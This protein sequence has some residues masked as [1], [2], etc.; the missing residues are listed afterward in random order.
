MKKAITTA[1]LTS[2]LVLNL[3]A[4]G[5]KQTGMAAGASAE[6]KTST[7]A[8]S[9]ESLSR[10]KSQSLSK[11]AERGE[12]YPMIQ[13]ISKASTDLLKAMALTDHKF[14][15]ENNLSIVG[16]EISSFFSLYTTCL[17]ST[18]ESRAAFESMLDKDIS[19]N[20][21]DSDLFPFTEFVRWSKLSEPN[22]ERKRLGSNLDKVARLPI[23]VSLTGYRRACYRMNF[24]LE[25]IYFST[26][27]IPAWPSDVI[28]KDK[29]K[30]F[31]TRLALSSH[32]ANAF[33]DEMLADQK[34][35]KAL[36]RSEVM[37]AVL[38]ASAR[39]ATDEKRWF[40]VL[41]K[42][43]TAFSN[44]NLVINISGSQKTAIEFVFDDSAY[45]YGSEAG[46]ITRGGQTWFGAGDTVSG[47]KYTI[48]I[49]ESDAQQMN[50]KSSIST[51]S[52][53]AAS[54]SAGAS[55]K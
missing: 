21:F 45:N 38:N 50:R 14:S 41:D 33:L 12:S 44:Q 27:P 19:I 42:G 53:D 36:T 46:V 47:I 2:A 6:I 13:V 3:T 52:K 40:A 24:A 37:T 32:I 20:A 11:S 18:V 51:G 1:L 39:L 4:C 48:A 35:K 7:D 8:S 22:E 26:K 25:S 5:E 54:G 49:K 15:F 16:N 30:E 23:G 28:R 10:E 34:F 43:L 55:V 31:V 17:G 29:K 9:D